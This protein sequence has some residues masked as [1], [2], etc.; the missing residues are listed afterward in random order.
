MSQ[1]RSL[2]AEQCCLRMY[3][4][5]VPKFEKCRW[6]NAGVVTSTA[7]SIQLSKKFVKAN[8]FIIKWLIFIKKK[9]LI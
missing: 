7:E 1:N 6:Q 9:G 4:F 8:K 2:N 3:H 5:N